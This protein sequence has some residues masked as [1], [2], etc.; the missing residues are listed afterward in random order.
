[1]NTR[2]AMRECGGAGGLQLWL[3]P[4]LPTCAMSFPIYAI[5]PVPKEPSLIDR[6][7]AARRVCAPRRRI[8]SLARAQHPRLGTRGARAVSRR[9]GG[10][11]RR[12][13]LAG[14]GSRRQSAQPRLCLPRRCRRA[15]ANASERR[16]HLARLRSTT[17]TAWRPSRQR[18]RQPLPIFAAGSR[19]GTCLAR[20]RRRLM[21]AQRAANKRPVRAFP[22]HDF[23]C[24]KRCH[25]HPGGPAFRVS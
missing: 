2:I 6:A 14:V 13:E 16:R 22:V 5:R 8:F 15:T 18:R 19:T 11:R 17:P 23:Q 12:G 10:A 1:M 21:R 7:L 20:H 24:T 4:A 9:R 3:V 25:Q